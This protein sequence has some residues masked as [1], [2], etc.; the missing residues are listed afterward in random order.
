MSET[1]ATHMDMLDNAS[2]MLFD[3]YPNRMAESCIWAAAHI[4][5]LEAQLAQ[6]DALAAQVLDRAIDMAERSGFLSIEEIRAI[7]SGDT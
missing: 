7:C 6:R 3:D 1:L 4:R 2:H 5:D